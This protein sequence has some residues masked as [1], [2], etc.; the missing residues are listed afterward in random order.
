MTGGSV[1]S[2]FGVMKMHGDNNSATF[3]DVTLNNTGGYGFMLES[4]AASN[5]HDTLTLNNV[6]LNH[7]ASSQPAIGVRA[8]ALRMDE[9]DI[10]STH[11]EGISV[12]GIQIGWDSDVKLV[13]GNITTAGQAAHGIWLTASNSNPNVFTA[14]A[15]TITASGAEAS[16]IYGSAG[17]GT[18]TNSHLKS[19][20]VGGRGIVSDS[21]NAGLHSI[22][23]MQG[24]DITV[25]GASS[26]GVFSAAG[27]EAHLDGV[28][29]TGA[30]ASS[31]GFYS[32]WSGVGTLKNSTVDTQN[33]AVQVYWDNAS[34]DIDASRVTSTGDGRF[35]LHLQQNASASVTNRSTIA[36]SGVNS[37]A[38]GFV[39]INETQ[40]AVITDSSALAMGAGGR[41]LYATG[42]NNR[43]D[44]TNSTFDG[45]RLATLGNV[46]AGGSLFGARFTVNAD[47][48]VFRGHTSLTEQ[49]TLTLNLNNG[50]DWLLRPSST[51]QNLSVVSFLNLNDSRVRF[52]A[53]DPLNPVFQNLL[54]GGGNLNG[55]TNV[56][57]AASN[58]RVTMNTLLNA[59]GAL[60]DQFTDRLLIN[61]DASGTTLLTVNAAAGSTGA[62]TGDT[63]SDGISLV[64]VYGNASENSF[65]LA[66]GYVPI[67][68]Y[69]YRLYAFDPNASDASQ[70]VLAT[71]LFWDFRLLS[72]RGGRGGTLLPQ[73]P[74]YLLAPTALFHAGRL[75][76]GMLHQRV[77]ESLPVQS[78]DD[79]G[80]TRDF[81]LRTYGGEVDYRSNHGYDA[82]S[83]YTAV[84]GGGNFYGIDKSESRWR[85]GLAGNTGDVSFQ[86]RQGGSVV[87][88]S[89]KT[90]MR[91]WSVSPTTTW[92]HA[93]GAY[94]DALLAY[95]KFDGDIANRGGTG[96]TLKGR[97]VA[98]SV[99][100]GR[101]FAVSAESTGSGSDAGFT[102]KPQVQAVYQRLRF[103]DLRD[104]DNL[105]ARLGTLSQWSIRAGGE[106]GKTFQTQAGHR[107][108][109]YG[110][111]HIV[112]TLG[113]GQTVRL[114]DERF[115]TGKSG[116]VAEIGL[117]FDALFAKDRAMLY[118]DITRQQRAS[119]AGH[120][121]WTVN[122][123]A[124]VR[125]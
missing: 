58:A 103:D 82:S 55:A 40:T 45:D 2:S 38:L 7:S 62:L 93:N 49:S 28:A 117:G 113:D 1:S 21:N 107:I 111:A 112:H 89:H 48:S 106:I 95:G 100:A 9:V 86:P 27:G 84:Q 36:A 12:L 51:G 6:T 92:Q 120:Q 67:G 5:S 69:E 115:H 47:N 96:T 90:R 52:A 110:K 15:M 37:A 32:F 99:E 73:A 50:S 79:P 54:V 26:I 91:V 56:Y 25:E 29:I 34:M 8:G 16:A 121:G 68:A 105:A 109:L 71:G 65:A 11:N 33:S 94:V 43:L 17:T 80:K 76:I 88:G 14:D 101:L 42:G 64:Q 83:R 124:R 98:A 46:S 3:T 4:D 87:D 123:G 18:M 81:F 97:N 116:T 63:A 57:N 24:G 23:H 13:N 70:R 72:G 122:L 53:P 119:R 61:G 114:D 102:V 22:I 20:G 118:A 78:G 108:Q 66:G 44:A 77:G 74:G 35:G 59:G 60:A 104:A 10:V 30:H 39:G 41:A 19:T 31:V 125:F 85:F 75:D